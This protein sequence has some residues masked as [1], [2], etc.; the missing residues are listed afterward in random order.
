[1]VATFTATVHGGAAYLPM[2]ETIANLTVMER[3][4][5]AASKET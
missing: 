3:I 2:T 1:M 4:L 5:E